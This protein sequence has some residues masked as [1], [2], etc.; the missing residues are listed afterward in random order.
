MVI[1]LNIINIKECHSQFIQKS[2]GL[3]G[4]PIYCLTA[5][6][7][8]IYA[9]TMYG[10][11]YVSTNAG[12]SWTSINNDIQNYYIGSI[13]IK[14]NTIFAGCLHSPMFGNG[15][16]TIKN[17][18]F[19]STNGGNNWEVIQN[20]FLYNGVYILALLNYENYIYSGTGN[21]IYRAT[22]STTIT[23][24]KTGSMN[25]C[26]YALTN[27][28][29]NIFAGTYQQ[30]VYRSTDNGD[31]W[32]SVNNGLGNNTVITFCTKNNKIFAGTEGGIYATTNN[33][34]NWFGVNNG[35]TTT[36]I[37][38]LTTY[39]GN[40]FAGTS[41]GIFSSSNDGANWEDASVGLR[42]KFFFALCNDGTNLYAGASNDYQGIYK[43]TNN[44]A[45]WQKSDNGLVA[46]ETWNIKALGNNLFVTLD[47]QGVFKSTNW[48]ESWE[49]VNNGLNSP[50]LRQLE[51]KGNNI[52]LENLKDLFVSTNYGVS[53]E[54]ASGGLSNVNYIMSL[55]S[56]GNNLY[57]GSYYTGFYKSTN[58]GANW[59]LLGLENADIRAITKKGN[60]LFV[61][62]D[63]EGMF[64]SSDE[65]A[66]WIEINN[67][68][69]P[70]YFLYA[71]TLASVGD[72]VF[73]GN[74]FRGGIYM[75]TN[76]GENWVKQ[77]NGIYDSVVF[78]FT[79]KDSIL[80][81]SDYTDGLYITKNLGQNWICKGDPL[82][83]KDVRTLCIA[84][85]YIF[86]GCNGFGVWRRPLS[87][88]ISVKQINTKVPEK[89]YLYQNY[90]NPFNPSTNIKFQ[91][92]DNSVITIKVYDIL[93]K[94]IMELVNGKY[95]SGVY[96]VHFDGS[97]LSSGTYFYKMQV[98][99][100]VQVRKMILTK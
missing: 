22:D 2:N 10:G 85:G 36:M 53:W 6:S 92:K 35:L 82:Y 61:G 31:S 68:L 46:P 89:M 9:G 91:V 37:T 54:L 80:F 3:N 26:V 14:D 44:G 24:K 48:G 13:L 8:K 73:L 70:T 59:T 79:T 27:N 20:G 1:V 77:N 4:G 29:N 63:T 81:A 86:A 69:P 96:E 74:V 41:E 33:G 64:L 76:N 71:R 51:V 25:F 78:A 15:G 99:D 57:L 62:S 65:G 19:R 12:N 49:G 21:G 16:F 60:L 90:P 43:S 50:Y 34:D 98:G 32:Q 83:Q 52:F 93:G 72:N 75:T 40:I 39:N 100:F 88:V 11:I 66:S 28:G 94:E 5:A 97:I 38:S 95:A 23:W 58:N 30:G 55:Y 56:D 84:G 67:G 18:M 47:F 7:G 17:F 45:N 42:A 87:E